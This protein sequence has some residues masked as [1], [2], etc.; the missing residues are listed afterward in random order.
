MKEQLLNITK[1]A[2]FGP[3]VVGSGSL[4]AGFA[5][6]W[7]LK[8]RYISKELD[9]AVEDLRVNTEQLTFDFD[10]S[11]GQPLPFLKVNDHGTLELVPD[12]PDDVTADPEK[13]F[14]LQ[15]EGDEETP[16]I[17]GIFANQV[18]PNWDY[19]E[20]L[21]KR[22]STE[23]YVIHRDEFYADETGWENQ[24]SLTYYDGDDVMCTEEDAVMYDYTSRVG[25]LKFGHGSGE[26]NVFYVRNEKLHVEYEI[27]REAGSYATD[28]LGDTIAQE[29]EEAD[30]QHF[31][32]PGK[33]RV[34]D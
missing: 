26:E 20:E 33:F 2:W 29:Y 3:A 19:E 18:D 32:R 11:F 9:K 6:G 27:T 25:E 17:V 4:G 28:I 22:S 13:D 34:R 8:K 30:L 14:D 12:D 23:P 31:N 1:K 15:E 16:N 7:M 24:M 5:L 21:K 10:T